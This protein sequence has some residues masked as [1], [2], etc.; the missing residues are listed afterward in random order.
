M[1]PLDKLNLMLPDLKAIYGHYDDV[2]FSRMCNEIIEI[3]EA[4]V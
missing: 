4:P 1:I 2:Q 3:P